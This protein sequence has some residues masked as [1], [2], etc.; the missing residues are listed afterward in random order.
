MTPILPRLIGTLSDLVRALGL[1]PPIA[2]SLLPPPPVVGDGWGQREKA[3]METTAG[4]TIWHSLAPTIASGLGHGNPAS[5][6]GETPQT[7]NPPATSRIEGS[8]VWSTTPIE[9]DNL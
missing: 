3:R 9:G 2:G 1:S 6:A 4:C 8:G 7:R 5:T